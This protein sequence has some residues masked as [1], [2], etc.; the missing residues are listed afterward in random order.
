MAPKDALPDRYVVDR[1]GTP[2]PE[3]S[4]YYVL[5]VVHDM[6]A[7]VALRGLVNKYRFDGPSVRADELEGLLNDSEPAFA[8]YVRKRSAYTQ[9]TRKK[10]KRS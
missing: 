2:D 3:A 7:R 4:R 6:E 8:E 5:D 1:R 9:S 10:Q